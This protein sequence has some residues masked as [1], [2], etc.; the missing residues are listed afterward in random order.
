MAK[1]ELPKDTREALARSLSAYIE[2]E[3]GLEVRGFDAQFLLD[4][5]IEALGPHLYNQGLADAQTILAAK[6]EEITDAIYQL[7]APAKL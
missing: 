1:I 6:L 5:M 7:E 4:H 3:L 2:R